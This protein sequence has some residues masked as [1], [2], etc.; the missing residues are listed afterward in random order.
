MSLSIFSWNVAGLR[1][2][3]KS[4]EN[5]NNNLS[6]ALF[7]KINENGENKNYDI[8]CLQ[9]TKCT[10]E[11]VL[12]PNDIIINFPYRYWNSTDGT[13]QRKGLSGTC[14]WCV[15]PPI[16]ALN[17]PDFDVEGR[18]VAP[19]ILGRLARRPKKH[20]AK[21]I[22]FWGALQGAQRKAVQHVFLQQYG[23]LHGTV[24]LLAPC[25]APKQIR[26]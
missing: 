13:S 21:P 3:V 26:Q 15:S 2:R 5:L 10:E 11:Q 8:V 16:R 18:I 6:R 14:I 22:G 12:L 1:A 4:D 7:P 24:I 25:E 9:E 23:V 19:P 17:T 20:I